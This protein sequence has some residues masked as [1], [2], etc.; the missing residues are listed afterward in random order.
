MERTKKNAR[1]ELFEGVL[2]LRDVNECE[3]FFQDL[4]SPSELEALSDRWRVAK[5]VAQKKPYRQ[6]YRKTGVS[7]ATVTRVA[8]ALQYGVG[9]F[10]LLLE[11]LESSSRI[12]S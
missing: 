6:I 10:R 12:R 4:C 11:R 3:Q 8:R 1:R 9:G 2:A 5:L 7:T